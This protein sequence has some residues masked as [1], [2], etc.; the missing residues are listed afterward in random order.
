VRLLMPG[1]EDQLLTVLKLVGETCNINCHYCYERRK[2]YDKS[3]YLRPALVERFLAACGGRPLAIQLHGGE[4][5]LMKR[6]LM[7]ELF[8]VLRRYP[9]P[10]HMAIQTN[11]TLL[12]DAWFEFLDEQWPSIE[13]GISMD[14]DERGNAHRVDFFDRPIYDRVVAALDVAARRDRPVGVIVVVTRRVLGRA[15]EVIDNLRGFPAVRAVKLSPCYDYNVVTKDYRTPN[16]LS[17]QVLNP[18]GVGM[19]GWATTPMEFAS[20]AAEAFDHWRTSGAF[21]QFSVEPFIGIIRTLGGLDTGYESYRRRKAPFVVT[22]YPDGRIGTTDEIDLP[23][24]QIGH[25]DELTSIDE[26]LGFQRNRALHEQF[27]RLLNKC[28]GC[29][30]ETTC[31]GGMLSERMPY[32]GTPFEDEYCAA[33]K[34]LLDHVERVVGRGQPVAAGQR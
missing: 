21:G 18:S 8:E 2:P 4:P 24:S 25:M 7:A 16:R 1:P 22:L 29:S 34:Y 17:L 20:F 23:Q 31:R 11:G 6:P 33:R 27:T 9:G 12:D 10:T 15:K 30:H 5:L 32:E 3:Q 13:I 19:P 26:F 28:S 14:G